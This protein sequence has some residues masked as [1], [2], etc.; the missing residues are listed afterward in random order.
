MITLK[1][2]SSVK[3]IYLQMNENKPKE[4]FN[5]FKITI[6][7][8]ISASLAITAFDFPILANGTAS[9]FHTTKLTESKIVVSLIHSNNYRTTKCYNEKTSV[10]FRKAHET[11]FNPVAS[12]IINSLDDIFDHC[13]IG[14]CYIILDKNAVSLETIMTV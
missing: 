7:G 11:E 12:Q 6:D 13:I 4:T 2:L 5:I 1:L 14:T 9:C 8:Q 3:L 10:I